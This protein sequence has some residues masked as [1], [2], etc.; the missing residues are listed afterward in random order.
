VNR[1]GGSS[2]RR[3]LALLTGALAV[4]VTLCVLG[5]WQVQR[6]AWKTELIARVEARLAA[7]PVPAPGPASWNAVSS[8]D[9]YRRLRV[10]GSYARGHDTLV[11]AVTTRGPGF[12]V[13]TPLTTTDGWTLLVNRGFVPDAARAEADRI[14]PQGSV[15]V[16]GLLRLD[17]PGGAFLRS[18]QPQAGRWYSRD[19]G[20]IAAAQ[21]LTGVAPYFIDADPGPEGSLPIG[22]L[23]VVSFRNSHLGYALT[24][25]SLAA[26]WAASLFWIWRQGSAATPL[27]DRQ[28]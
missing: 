10:Q 7:A 24:W 26:L 14:L 28:R 19:T 8:E 21:G 9:E 23:T 15:G 18:N 4:F 27:D 22:G 2:P 17:Q 16:T 11:K 1:T 13:M 3:R 20:A 12:W 5:I 25:F 6:L